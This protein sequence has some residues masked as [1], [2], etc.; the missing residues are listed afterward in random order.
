[1]DGQDLSPLF[2]GE[3]LPERAFA[4]GGYGPTQRAANR[5]YPALVS[6][7]PGYAVPSTDPYDRLTD[8]DAALAARNEHGGVSARAN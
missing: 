1:M 6:Y 5:Q 2:D 7:F 3:D 4:Y 8:A